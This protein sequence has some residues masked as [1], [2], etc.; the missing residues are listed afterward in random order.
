MHFPL[1]NLSSV[2]REVKQKFK[3]GGVDRCD[4][5]MGNFNVLDLFLG[6]MC[7]IL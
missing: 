5:W 3:H 7:I 1:Y 4:I 6:L 2:L